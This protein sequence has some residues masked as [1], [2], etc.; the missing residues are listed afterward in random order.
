MAERKPLTL[1]MVD[2]YEYVVNRYVE[3]SNISDKVVDNYYLSLDEALL[4]SCIEGL[5]SILTA[6]NFGLAR[7]WRAAKKYMAETGFRKEKEGKA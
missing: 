6:Y 7:G 5:N 1:D 3:G 2:P 4:I